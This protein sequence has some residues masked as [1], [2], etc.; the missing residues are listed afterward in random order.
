MEKVWAESPKAAVV[1][2]M[3]LLLFYFYSF[4]SGSVIM[5]W[6][7]YG[8]TALGLHI[9]VTVT[10]TYWWVFVDITQYNHKTIEVKA[11]LYTRSNYIFTELNCGQLLV[12]QEKALENHLLVLSFVHIFAIAPTR[13]GFNYPITQFINEITAWELN[14]LNSL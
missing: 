11:C 1:L 4:H 13:R 2:G 3:D 12:L 6:H 10:A 5:M 14:Y 9:M 8:V 7:T